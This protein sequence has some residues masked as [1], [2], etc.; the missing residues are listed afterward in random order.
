MNGLDQIK[1]A[2]LELSKINTADFKFVDSDWSI[3]YQLD[4]DKRLQEDLAKLE[5]E[6]NL[7]TDAVQRKDMVTAKCALVMARVISLDLSNFFLNIFEDIEKVGWGELCELPS[8]P[9][10][11]VIPEHYNYPLDK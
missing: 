11:Y 3:D 9:E 7:L 8:I 6:L 4:L 1:R 2:I 10:N 5:T